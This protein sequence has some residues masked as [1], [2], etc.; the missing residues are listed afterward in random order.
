MP[1]SHLKSSNWDTS[2]WSTDHAFN[3]LAIKQKD[4]VSKVHIGLRGASDGE[5]GPL[6]TQTL[7]TIHPVAHQT[8]RT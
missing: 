7:C 5:H 8:C 2:K 4:R 1:D 3:K 6:Y